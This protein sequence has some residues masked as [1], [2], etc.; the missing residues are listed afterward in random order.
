MIQVRKSIEVSERL[1]LVAGVLDDEFNQHFQS[2]PPLYS[3]KFHL[4]EQIFLNSSN[5]VHNSMVTLTRTLP[6]PYSF[7]YCFFIL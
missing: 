2:A 5:T 7:F 4:H 6:T 3:E 1:A